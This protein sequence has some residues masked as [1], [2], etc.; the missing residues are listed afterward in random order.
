MGKIIFFS[1]G[2][3]HISRQIRTTEI[4]DTKRFKISV[5]L[6]LS[7]VKIINLTLLE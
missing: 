4:W 7:V 1:F 3:R 5:D 6:R 2:Q